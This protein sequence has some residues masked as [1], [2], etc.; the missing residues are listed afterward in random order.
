[1]QTLLREE[2]LTPMTEID[3]RR[4]VASFALAGASVL[5]G[6]AHGQQ[7]TPPTPPAPNQPPAARF[8]Y[9]D[10]V[11]R[12][13]ELAS[14][15]FVPVPPLGEP[16]SRIDAE[17]WN[18]IRFKADKALFSGN[19]QLFRLQ[20]FHLGG[21]YRKPVVVNTIRDGIVT[22]IPYAPT[23]FDYGR[24]KL[25][26]PPGVNTGF[27]GFRL[28]FP[29]NDPR[30]FDEVL[31]VLGNQIRFLG[32]GQRY[33]LSTSALLVA[34]G[35]A[36]QPFLREFWIET[37]EAGQ[38]RAIGYALLDGETLTGAYRFELTPGTTSAIDVRA[39]LFARKAGTSVSF[40]PLTSSFFSGENDRRI[41]TDFRP[42]MHNSDGLLI[43]NGAGEWLWRP[44]RNPG[45]QEFSAFIDS[46]PR[47]FGLMQRDRSF[48]HYQDLD[49]GFE[50]RPSY[51]V[52][53]QGDW[54]EGFV[55]LIENPAADE[56][57]QNISVAFTPKAQPEPGK[58][59]T[60][61]YRVTSSLDQPREALGIAVSTYQTQAKA[62]GAAQAAAP[63]S[64][65]FI[66]DFSGGDLPYFHTDPKALE[67][68]ASTSRG[69]ILQSFIAPNPH[70]RG[71]RVG[72]DV[73]VP[74]GEIADLRVNLRAGGRAVTETWTL[75]W[76]G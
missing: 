42:E 63:N 51:W 41:A 26:K 66:I 57:A 59:F 47:G 58:P 3:R 72:I 24:T 33:G 11:K 70:T 30:N 43:S 1:M 76:K 40:A 46:N 27:A 16:L 53:P 9:E 29:L 38:E 17:G 32:R 69:S 75:P 28:H 37:P 8:G 55:Q 71:F 22:P 65:R 56:F 13:K 4:L 60:F 45:T 7:P 36:Q 62:V 54:G 35:D 19:N 68:V 74:A 23:L 67:V 61:A 10:V 34:G 6:A 18:E 48:A 5:T 50:L 21:P 39:T 14:A 25:E 20:A 64:R 31:A 2:L 15:A 12:A 49:S 44:L 73:Q 52:E